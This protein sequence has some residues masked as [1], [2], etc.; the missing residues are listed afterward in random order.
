MKVTQVEKTEFEYVDVE[1]DGEHLEYRRFSEEGWERLWG[2]S[3]EC[4]HCP[5]EIEMLYQAFV[6]GTPIRKNVS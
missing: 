5:C 1:K 3:W 6:K 4:V 2:M